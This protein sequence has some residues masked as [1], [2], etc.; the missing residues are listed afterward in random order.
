MTTAWVA[1]LLATY[2]GQA[3]FGPAGWIAERT[4]RQRIAAGGMYAPLVENGAIWRLWTC[5]FVHVDLVHLLSN[6]VALWVLGRILEPMVGG[7]RLSAWF[8]AGGVVGASLSKAVGHVASDGASGG[9][10]ALLGAAVV[11]G[12]RYRR[13]LPPDDAR[14][15]GPVLGAFLALN[16]LLS[17]LPF[18]DLVAHLGGLATGTVLAAGVGTRT[19]AALHGIDASWVLASVAICAYGLW[20]VMT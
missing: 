2:A 16:L 7:W 4:A 11:L 15:L 8:L 1:L 9:A 5:L 6:T 10:F 19:S 13:E 14:L 3:A 17:L 20:R 12:F 18:I